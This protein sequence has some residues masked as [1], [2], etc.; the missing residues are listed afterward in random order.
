MGQIGY[1]FNLIFTFPILNVLMLLDHV[2][3]DFGLSIVILTLV[4]RLCLFPLTLKQLRSTKATQA[5]QPLMADI[6]KKYT[7]QREQYAEMQRLYK[8]Y[9]INPVAGCLPL[10][11][12]MPIIYGLYEA[13]RIILTPSGGHLSLADLNDLIYPFLP[14]FHAMPSFTLSWFTFINPHWYISL[15]QADPTHILPI[16]AGLATFVQLRMSQA[17]A[18]QQRTPSASGKPDMMS[19]QMQ[20]MSFVMPFITLFIAWGFPAGLALYWT[21]TSIFSMVQQYF[22][23][24]WGSLFSL[25]S[26]LGGGRQPKEDNGVSAVEPRRERNSLERVVDSSAEVVPEK[27]PRATGSLYSGAGS[28]SSSRRRRPNSASARRRGNVPR[29]NASRS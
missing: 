25:P 26:F 27:G 10:L 16:L 29:R 6:R 5:I 28:S 4:V 21:T 3:G 19:Q 23:T 22:V 15:A 8:E 24:G 1:V 17:R 9:N 2:F 11:V 14:T 12:Q 18:A 7:D 20:I 13:M